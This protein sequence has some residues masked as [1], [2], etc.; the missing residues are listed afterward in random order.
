MSNVNGCTWL[1][2]KKMLNASDCY[3]LAKS[4]QDRNG[5]QSEYL[6]TLVT[7]WGGAT[8]S[9]NQ[10][11]HVVWLTVASQCFQVPRVANFPT[12]LSCYNCVAMEGNLVTVHSACSMLLRMLLEQRWNVQYV[13][14]TV[15]LMFRK[16]F[17]M[18]WFDQRR[19]EMD[20]MWFWRQLWWLFCGILKTC[21]LLSTF[22]KV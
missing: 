15:D 13:V 10:R 22:A 7:F 9:S 11:W 8:V 16:I 18:W 20:V 1:R 14:T 6:W 4:H 19:V 12:S 5:S 3:S 2:L 17:E 21:R